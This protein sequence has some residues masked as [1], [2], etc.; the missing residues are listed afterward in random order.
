MKLILVS[1]TLTTAA[2]QHLASSY[3]HYSQEIHRAKDAAELDKFI[4]HL[5][6]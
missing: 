3:A 1:L 6:G 5:Q 4:R 2:S